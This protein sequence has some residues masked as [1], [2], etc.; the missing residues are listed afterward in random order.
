[1][2]DL[3]STGVSLFVPVYPYIYVHKIHKNNNPDNTR[4][5]VLLINTLKINIIISMPDFNVNETS[6]AVLFC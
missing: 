5:Y 2:F 6:G 4:T 3:V 1:M